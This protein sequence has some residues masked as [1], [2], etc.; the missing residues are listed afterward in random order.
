MRKTHLPW[1]AALGFAASLAF[2]SCAYDPNYTSVGA[3]YRSGYGYGQGYGSS[4][5]STS[6]FVSTGDPRWG[7]DPYSYSYYD[8]RTRRFYDP[9]LYGYY[10]IGYRPPVV[11]GVPH[12]YGW[13]PGR[14]YCPPPRTVRNVTVVNYHDRAGAYRN[15]NHSW[16]RQVRQQS[17][18]GDRNDGRYGAR[19]NNNSGGPGYHS[20]P[21]SNR[22]S[23]NRPES[24]PRQPWGRG[25]SNQ[26]I[27]GSPDSSRNDNP[28]QMDERFIRPMESRPGKSRAQNRLPNAYNTPVTR[29]PAMQPE[30]PAREFRNEPPRFDNQPRQNRPPAMEQPSRSRN[31]GMESRPRPSMA[32]EMPGRADS[33]QPNIQRMPQDFPPPRSQSG[34]SRRGG[35]R[36]LG[37]G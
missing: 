34:H 4:N 29:P 17:Y 28:P 15:T 20:G 23:Y 16:A 36:S 26:N 8:Y 6:L 25:G 30:P 32:P 22:D 24:G 5:F 10:P 31:P 18:P 7:Y 12:P 35:L 3:S 13:R 21:S 2:S 19:P 1:A 33:P 11:Y 37:D 27:I 9:Y 14:G